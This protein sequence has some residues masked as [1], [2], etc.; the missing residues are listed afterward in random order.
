[1]R[2]DHRRARRRRENDGHDPSLRL[3][4]RE[5]SVGVAA[6]EKPTAP[7]PAVIAARSA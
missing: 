7:T 4:S 2:G 3:A 1:M 5:R 6:R